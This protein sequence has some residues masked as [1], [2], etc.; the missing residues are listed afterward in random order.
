MSILRWKSTSI[1]NKWIYIYHCDEKEYVPE[2][3]TNLIQTKHYYR[4]FGS[5]Y[6]T[7]YQYEIEYHLVICSNCGIQTKIYEK[8]EQAVEAW[9]RRAKNEIQK[10][11]SSN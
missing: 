10:E 5:D 9:N 11:A 3:A 1:S 7:D 6:E 8:E 4:S 2:N